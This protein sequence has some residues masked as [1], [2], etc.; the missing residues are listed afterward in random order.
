MSA[1]LPVRYRPTS[2]QVLGRAIRIGLLTAAVV[3]VPVAVLWINGGLV[4]TEVLLLPVACV[5]GALLAGP[6]LRRGGIDV[7][8][9]GVHPVVPGPTRREYAPWH[10]IVDIRAERRGARTVPVIYL[11]GGRS[12]RLRV[13]YDGIALGGDPHFDEKLSTIRN[14]WET[15]RRDVNGFGDT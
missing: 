14:M 7:D 15:Y 12:W 10:A 3:A 13:P 11:D 8:E 9:L 1:N 6:L 4:W 2:R 5:A